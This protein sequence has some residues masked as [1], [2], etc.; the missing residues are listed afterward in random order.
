MSSPRK[1]WEFEKKGFEE[2]NL[3]DLIKIFGS[4]PATETLTSLAKVDKKTWQSMGTT[5]GVLKDFAASG[6]VKYFDTIQETWE[7]QVENALSPLT[8]QITESVAKILEPIM[9]MITAFIDEMTILISDGMTVWKAI[10]TGEWDEWFKTMEAKM[11]EWL[12]IYKNAIQE[13]FYRIFQNIENFIRDAAA[14]P[15]VADIATWVGQF[16]NNMGWI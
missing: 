7:L 11:P 5:V 12:K 3:E 15:M 1:D 2:R 10:L 4:K 6:G 8:N 13:F 9:P 14:N 16:W